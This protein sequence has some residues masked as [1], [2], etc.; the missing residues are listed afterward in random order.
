MFGISKKGKT[1]SCCLAGSSIVFLLLVWFVLSCSCATKPIA[2]SHSPVSECTLG[3]QTSVF[4]MQP[5]LK[6]ERIESETDIP[7]DNYGGK[8][9][10]SGI[11]RAAKTTLASRKFSIVDYRKQTGKTAEI[12]CQ[13]CSLSS[14]LSQGVV[15]DN[16]KGLLGSL[17]GQV[18]GRTA[19][20]NSLKVKVGSG[21]SWDPNS[22][23][24]TSSNT[25]SVLRAALLNCEE[26]SVLWKNQVLLRQ[27]PKPGDPKFNEALM[28]LY[29]NF[30][31]NKVN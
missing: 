23:A 17:G 5:L 22:G 21:G 27:L 10:E 4:I 9:I 30:P 2:I 28:L 18:E 26:G 25:Y 20:L 19:L 16:S 1:G 13:V 12:C 6:F 8:A 31:Q 15:D 11:V 3:Q 24:I 29:E 14:R 7:A